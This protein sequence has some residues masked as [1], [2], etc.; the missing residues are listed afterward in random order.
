DDPTGQVTLPVFLL[1]NRRVVAPVRATT[2]VRWSANSAGGPP[3]GSVYVV[4]TSDGA[5]PAVAVN[6]GA[7][8]AIDHEAVAPNSAAAPVC[9]RYPCVT[10]PGFCPV[11]SIGIWNS[12][13]SPGTTLVAP[14]WVRFLT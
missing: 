6:T 13:W 7:A 9:T 2:T 5:A 1:V 8:M 12:T 4:D 10:V 3:E 11:A 14:G